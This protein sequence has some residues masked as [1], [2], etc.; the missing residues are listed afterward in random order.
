MSPKT[1][2]LFD[3][4]GVI[5]Q[6][7]YRFSEKLAKDLNISLKDI[8]AFFEGDFQQCVVGKA[9]LKVIIT[10]YLDKWGWSKSTDQL[11]DFW[12]SYESKLNQDLVELIPKLQ[13]QDI[14]CCLCT[15][16]EKYRAY[17][18]NEQ[19]KFAKLFNHCFYSAEMH[20]KKPKEKYWDYIWNSLNY[21]TDIDNK[22]QVKFWDDN[23]GH[24]ES[25]LDFGFDA[26]LFTNNDQFLKEIKE[27][28]LISIKN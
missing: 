23:Q 13:S 2:F 15:N 26:R 8:E 16:Q 9:D 18:L 28:D 27:L 5:I 19:L 17:Y 22:S 10:P 24:V 1:C 12:F 7:Q 6:Y 21:L 25:A 3:A 11:L 14:F 20:T 4:V